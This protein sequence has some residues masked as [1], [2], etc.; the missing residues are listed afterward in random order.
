[1]T[2]NIM[3]LILWRHA[4]AR[5]ARDG[6]S[7]ADRPLTSK[8]DRQAHRMAHWLNQNL[9]ATTRVLA[10]PTLRTVQTVQALGRKYKL[11]AE[12]AP[13]QTVNA[14]LSVVRWPEAKEPVLVV[15][16]QF[17]LGLAAAYLMAGATQPWVV[18]KGA[19]W[20]LRCRHREA[21]TDV[22]LHTVLSPDRA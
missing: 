18:R 6:E 22:V 14:L 7:D 12:L 4:D 19:I 5:D 16:H 8:G 11:I 17:T 1:M 10:S 20:W 13:D 3:D 9:P 2:P 21:G 15:G